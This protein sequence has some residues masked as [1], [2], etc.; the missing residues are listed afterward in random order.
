ME[1]NFNNTINYLDLYYS[2][3]KKINKCVSK[4]IY[5][6]II[7][8]I[9]KIDNED[10]INKIIEL[11]NNNYKIQEVIISDTLFDNYNIIYFINNLNTRI[12]I[13]IEFINNNAKLF[14]IHNFVNIN[15]NILF[16]I[17][18][19]NLINNIYFKNFIDLYVKHKL[20]YIIYFY[21]DTWNETDKYLIINNYFNTLSINNSEL[22]LNDEIINLIQKN[23]S[24]TSMI[25]NCNSDENLIENIVKIFQ[26]KRNIN[27]LDLRYN[28]KIKSLESLIKVLQNYD[29]LLYLDLSMNKLDQAE[30]L[31]LNLLPNIRLFV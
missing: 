28:F 30:I 4:T 9:L 18:C 12:D 24:I 1:E 20:I 27:N 14:Y 11:I 29:T 3:I 2:I 16:K 21:N 13:C 10:L 7:E 6:N 23:N 22:L 19:D 25:V 15:N 26:T 31:K 17:K 8:N 5:N